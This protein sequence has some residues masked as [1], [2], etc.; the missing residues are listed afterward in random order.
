MTPNNK[1][2]SNVYALER[3]HMAAERTYFSVLRTGLAIAGAG[4]VIVHAGN[5]QMKRLTARL[6]ELHERG[7]QFTPAYEKAKLKLQ[8]ARDKNAEKYLPYLYQGIERLLPVLSE[9]GVVLAIEY[10]PSW[11]SIPASVN[12][13][14]IIRSCLSGERV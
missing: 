14:G 4:T 6:G 1:P 5:V 11:E 2:D 9:T 7:K 12:N 10:L 3:T 8:I 13:R